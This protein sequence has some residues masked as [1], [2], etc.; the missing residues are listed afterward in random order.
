MA[1]LAYLLP[2]VTGLIAFLFAIDPRLRFHG[3][4]SV[5]LG[6]VWPVAIYA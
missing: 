4:Q 6:A 3:L 2:P 5:A 1:A